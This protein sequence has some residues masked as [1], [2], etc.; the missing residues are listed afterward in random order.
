MLFLCVYSLEAN[1]QCSFFQTVGHFILTTLIVSF[2]ALFERKYR[3]F[4]QFSPQNVEKY[5]P[6]II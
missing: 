5:V 4:V 6:N 1:R 2:V 3:Y